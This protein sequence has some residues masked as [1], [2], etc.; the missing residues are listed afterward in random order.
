MNEQVRIGVG[1]IRYESNSFAGTSSPGEQF[2]GTG[3]RHGD[4][5]IDDAPTNSELAGARGEAAQDGGIELIGTVDTFGGCGAPLNDAVYEELASELLGRLKANAGLDAVYLALHGAMTTTAREDVE[6]DLLGRVRDLVGSTV[7]IVVSFDL[8]AAVSERTIGIVDAVIGYKTCP[9][10]DF[11]QTGQRAIRLAAAASRRTVTPAVVR[12]VVPILTAAEAHDTSTGPLAQ[13]MDWLQQQVADRG[14]IDGSIFACQP[15]LDTTRSTW[16]V[17]VTG[18]ARRADGTSTA[19]AMAKETTRRLIDAI[20]SFSATKTPVPE[21]W[22]AIDALGSG[23]VL[24]SDSGDSPSAGA[25]G[26]SIDCL[27]VLLDAGRPSVLATVTDADAVAAAAAAGIGSTITVEV[28]GQ[29]TPGLDACLCVTGTVLALADGRYM[30]VY[31]AAPVDIGP[32]AVMHVGNVD[33]VLTSRPAFMLDTTLFE[34]LGI[35]ARGYR[36]VQVKSAGGFRALWAPVSTQVVV[37]DSLGASSSRLTTMPFK[38]LP[39]GLWPFTP[40]RVEEPLR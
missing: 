4:A 22:A 39:P 19:E 2:G 20:D 18:D 21:I 23:T 24:V 38:K 34:H 29:H 10:T 35:D 17:T 33:L 36:V 14:L 32:C 31:P 12:A 1:G 28:G 5:V 15:W 11:V 3:T 40:I 30:R 7:P 25:A 37:A 8:H 9:H 13:H 6:A 16:T 26:D 27:R